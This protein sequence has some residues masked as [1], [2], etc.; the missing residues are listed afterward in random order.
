MKVPRFANTGGRFLRRKPRREQLTPPSGKGPIQG[1]ARTQATVVASLAEQF[2]CGNGARRF[3]SAFFEHFGK[4][5][6]V[7]F[8]HIG[9]W[10]SFACPQSIV[11]EIAG[12]GYLA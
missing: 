5:V 8:E 12:G 2:S 10:V 1:T 4:K 7:S 3:C 11:V 9:M 6:F